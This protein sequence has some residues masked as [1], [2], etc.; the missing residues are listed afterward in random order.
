MI[1]TY[2]YVVW[3]VILTKKIDCSCKTVKKKVGC[4]QD[5]EGVSMSDNIAV[6]AV[7]TKKQHKQFIMLPWKIYKNDSH[8][9]PQLI[10]DQKMLI[11]TKKKPFYE[12][13]ELA[14]FLAY[15]GKEVVGRIGAIINQMHEELYHEGVGHFGFFEAIDDKQIAVAL[16]DAAAQ[17][18]K[19]NGKKI[20]RGPANP[21]VWDTNGL[22]IDAFDIDPVILT[23]YNPQYYIALYEAYGFKKARD[24]YAYYIDHTMHFDPKVERITNILRKKKKITIRN[25]DLKKAKKELKQEVKEELDLFKIVFNEAW[26]ANWEYVPLTE[27]ELDFLAKEL[28]PIADENLILLAFVDGDIAGFSLCIP[29]FNIALKRIN[30]RLLPFGLLK[31]LAYRKKINMARVLAM[32]IRP[33]YRKMGI[34]AIFY[35]ETYQRGIIESVYLGGECSLIVEDNY[36]MR[37][38]LKGIKTKEYKTYRMYDKKLT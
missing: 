35:Y 23:A 12:H 4:V 30:G 15:K 32:G 18:L 13:S 24:W 25:I 36:D 28:I 37:D 2:A 34:D 27:H 1:I 10:I 7:T 26:E 8:W 5:Q 38:V 9:V 6:T 21:S 29:D 31:I 14:L 22:L 16:F 3:Q 20:M 17:W 33:K 11:N 19:A